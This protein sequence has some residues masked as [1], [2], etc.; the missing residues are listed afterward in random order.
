LGNGAALSEQVL[1]PDETLEFFNIMHRARAEATCSWFGRT[2]IA[3]QRALQFLV[4]G[5]KPYHCA[6]GDSLITVQPNGEI[7][8]CRRMPISVGNLMET[9][10]ID[11]YYKNDL[12]LALRDRSRITDGCQSCSYTRICRG[13]LKCLSYAVSG[14][15]F[16]AD[17]GCWL[18]SITQNKTS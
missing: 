15:P 12:F 5:G 14:D 1:T 18:T 2:E 13:G 3:M 10:L 8:P 9:P 16:K 4:S 6:A 11:L 7:Y 17:P